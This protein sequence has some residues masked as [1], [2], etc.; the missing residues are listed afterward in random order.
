MSVLANDSFGAK[1]K[2]SRFLLFSF[3]FAQFCIIYW[4]TEE[5]VYSSPRNILRTDCCS[6]IQMVR[7]KITGKRLNRII[8]WLKDGSP[9]NKFPFIP[10]IPST[11]NEFLG[12]NRS[13]RER[14]FRLSTNIYIYTRILSRGQFPILLIL[15]SNRSTWFSTLLY[16]YFHPLLPR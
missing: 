6:E 11:S 15:P 8:S 2:K 14:K 7:R 13:I 3:F 5:R 9:T 4:Q 10:S 12:R 16:P 1:V